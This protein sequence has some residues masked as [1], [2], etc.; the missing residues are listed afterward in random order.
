MPERN[1]ESVTLEE[2]ISMHPD[3]EDIRSTFLNLDRALKYIHD[4]GYCIE[5]FYPTDIDVLNDD[6]QYIQFNKLMELPTDPEL[7]KQ[8][9]QED[10]YHS[11]LIQVA[12]YASCLKYLNPEF[13]KENFDSFVQFIPAGDVPYYRGVIQRGASVYF[14]E[15]AL[16]KRNRDLRELEAQL[17]EEETPDKQLVKENISITNDAVNDVIYRQ[18]NGLKD[19]AFIN[20]LLIPTILLGLLSVF[21]V[22]AWLFSLFS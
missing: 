4:H 16:E 10:I 1:A 18:I 2:W 15:Y 9:I 3:S 6:D 7:R 19:K 8:M 12:I 22:I 13:L 20:W 21:G 17:G 11:S 14:C 5:V